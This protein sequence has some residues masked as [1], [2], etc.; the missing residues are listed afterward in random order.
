MKTRDLIVAAGSILS[1]ADT[2][3]MVRAPGVATSSFP[4]GPAGG[5]LGTPRASSTLAA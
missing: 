1:W 2:S 3:A 4:P 5:A